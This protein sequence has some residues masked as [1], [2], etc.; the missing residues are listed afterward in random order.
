MQDQV[1]TVLES[2]R[3]QREG[4][5]MDL[6]ADG[7]ID[8]PQGRARKDGSAITNSRANPNYC[9]VWAIDGDV[10]PTPLCVWHPSLVQEMRS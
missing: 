5:I 1:V 3:P 4:V 7:R 2:L 8:V 6:V 9:S 10:E